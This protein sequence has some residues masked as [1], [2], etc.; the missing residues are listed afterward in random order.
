MFRNWGG[1]IRTYAWR[2]QKP[3]PYRL[4]T[5]QWTLESKK[6]NLLCYFYAREIVKKNK[7]NEETY[8]SM[9]FKDSGPKG[10][11]LG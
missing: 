10:K 7:K 1:R 2:Y 8:P 4:A 11:L 6:D 5:P 9:F 3:L